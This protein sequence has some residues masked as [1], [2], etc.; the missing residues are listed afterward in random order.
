[1]C[2]QGRNQQNL[3]D[4]IAQRFVEKL[5]SMDLSINEIARRMGGQPPQRIRDVLRG[6]ARLP[7]DLLALSVGIGMDVNYV[8]TGL[9]NNTK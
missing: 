3:S 6:K 7:T 5:A 4:A 8:L 2:K 1:M 9:I